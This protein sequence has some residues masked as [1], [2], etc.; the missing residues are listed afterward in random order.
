MNTFHVE[1]NGLFNLYSPFSSQ[2]ASLVTIGNQPNNSKLQ[3]TFSCFEN[4]YFS[5]IKYF[6]FCNHQSLKGKTCEELIQKH[7][8][9]VLRMLRNKKNER[10]YL[11]KICWWSKGTLAMMLFGKVLNCVY[12]M[13]LIKFN[14]FSTISFM[15]VI[16]DLT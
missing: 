7:F 16:M 1:W 9:F 11:A 14:T 4:M 3:F 15:I 12:I 10:K 8:I 5:L 2:S 13:L 6:S